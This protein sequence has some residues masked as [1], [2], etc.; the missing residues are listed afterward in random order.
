MAQAASRRLLSLNN[1]DSSVSAVLEGSGTISALGESSVNDGVTAKVV[2]PLEDTE[3]VST[4]RSIDNP[5]PQIANDSNKSAS[6]KRSKKA[7]KVV[8]DI[9]DSPPSNASP[10]KP[11]SP[12]KPRSPKKPKSSNIGDD[13][14]IISL[15]D[16]K[17]I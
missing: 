12:R 14:E 10:E 5:D 7:P 15:I 1:P 11:K 17:N 13:V 3:N 4:D 2:S 16:D 9:S 8:I 6:P